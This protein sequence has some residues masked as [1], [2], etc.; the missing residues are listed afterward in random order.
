MWERKEMMYGFIAVF[1]ISGIIINYMMYRQRRAEEAA[2]KEYE[3][4]IQSI[5]KRNRRYDK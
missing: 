4:V 3:M 5:K 2:T 1:F